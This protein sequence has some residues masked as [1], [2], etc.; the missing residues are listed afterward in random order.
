MGTFHRVD[1]D[2]RGTVAL[3]HLADG[4][5]AVVFEDFKI[6]SSQH[7]NVILVANA[8]VTKDADIDQTKI[9]DLGPLTGTVGMQDYKVPPAMTA[10]AM[11]YHT[12]VLWDTAMKHA[13]AAAPL[14]LK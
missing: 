6:D 3:E 11:G 10:G 9:V 2:A 12:V 5:F 13:I 8:D 7:T 1:A 14:A 4:S